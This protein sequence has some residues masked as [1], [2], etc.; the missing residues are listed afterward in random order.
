MLRDI[1]RLTGANFLMT[2]TGAAA[3]AMVP[4]AGK[5]FAMSLWRSETR[6]LLDA[7]GWTG[8]RIVMRAFDGGATLQVSAPDDALYAA[9]QIVEAGW[10]AARA[11]LD[12]EEAPDRAAVAEKLIAAIAKERN[13][14][15]VALAAEAAA[16]GVTYLGHD[17]KV[18]VGLGQGAQVWPAGGAPD[19]ADVAWDEVHD[20]PVAMI[21][22]TNGKSTTVRLAAAIG[23]AA[24]R[25]VGLSSSDWVRVGGEI[26][27]EGD[28]S[29]PAGA[30]LAVRD[31]RV[32]MAIIETARGGLMRRGL[33]VPT[34]NV[35]LLT[36]IAADHLG[37]YG[38]V[39]VPALADAKF[40]LADAVRPGG[41][42]VLNADDPE[43][44]KRSARFDGDITWY[45]T[46]Q[47]QAVLDV[48]IEN[49]G[50][51]V[52]VEDGQMVLARDG[53]KTPV[54]PVVDFVPGMR[55]AAKYNISNALG[56]IGLTAALGLPVE[57]MT[58]ALGSFSN[59]PDENPGRGNFIELGGATLLIDFAH[60]P[61]GILALAEAVKDVPA[62]RR[63]FLA[64]QAG[65][66]SD[67][68]T[69]D[70]TQAVW[71]GNPDMVVIKELPKKLR[72]RKL[73]ELSNIIED[74]LIALGARPEQI[75][76][77]DDE[78]AAVQAA[79]RWAQPGD[80]L[81]LLLHADRKPSMDLIET[82]QK[83]GWR[84]GDPVPD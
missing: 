84:A 68:D 38:I 65:D 46:D 23:A 35:C 44:V 79:L 73:G 9:T 49:G 11:R 60:N 26:L 10:T 16:R 66:R 5:G 18:S 70:M 25:C 21:T 24:G 59:S 58:T 28:Y 39:D 69:R 40:L 45:G 51:A 53:V 4:E 6:A 78:F 33:P 77:T 17:G 48:W 50:H 55:G 12:G 19:V 81:V 61:H 31:P 83:D 56:A 74:E 75:Q 36:N 22:G 29:G 7:V 8:E 30:R 62:S 41:R 3:E 71:A 27:D 13:P 63:L 72:G 76:K 80:L 82:L 42:L 64:G 67:Q 34:A 52:F 57:A 43:L 2:G 1:R 54:L 32:D 37:G 15:E 47:D 14:A 20:I